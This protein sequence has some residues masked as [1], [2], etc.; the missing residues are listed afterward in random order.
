MAHTGWRCKDCRGYVPDEAHRVWLRLP[1]TGTP[2]RRFR[3]DRCHT[4]IVGALSAACDHVALTKAALDQQRAEQE[5]KRINLHPKVGMGVTHYLGDDAYPYTIVRKL[6]WRRIVIRQDTARLT[7]GSPFSRIQLYAYA[8]SDIGLEKTLSLRTDKQWRE[9][10]L[11]G[12][13]ESR[14]VIG[15]RLCYRAPSPRGR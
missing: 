12:A 4:H 10:G 2:E 1:N 15:E 9:V 14:F 11:R 3:C 5:Q 8:G 6:S 13:P 7:A